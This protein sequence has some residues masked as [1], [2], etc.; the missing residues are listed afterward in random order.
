M[1]SNRL[2]TL[3]LATVSVTT[4]GCS[5]ND[6]SVDESADA[7]TGV[8]DLTE[9]EAAFG[10]VKDFKDAQGNWSRP[11]SKLENGPCFK[12]LRGG[13]DGASYEF[14]RYT[15]G[16]AFFKRENAGAASGPRRPVL[17]MDVDLA[18]PG[19][20]GESTLEFSDLE[21]D[22]AIR[23]RIGRPEGLEGA[24]GSTYSG[25]ENGYFRY[26]NMF[27]DGHFDALGK[28]ALESGCLS[29]VKFPGSNGTDASL[30]TLVYQY[31]WKNAQGTD[32]YSF[33]DD[34][35]GRYVSTD[36][37]A[38]VQHLRFEKL[39]AHRIAPSPSSPAGPTEMLAITRKGVDMGIVQAALAVC[40]RT[41]VGDGRYSVSCAGL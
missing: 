8:T 1:L 36:G 3:V 24:A 41:P 38:S 23:Y 7:V 14:R 37:D 16:A 4:F 17:C 39:D 19:L 29:E 9:V 22:A 32:L 30:V 35:V 13:P 12:K 31:A 33:Q 28:N 2:V 18:V 27:C 10:L 34:P 15:N 20:P 25:F 26:T 40:S 6:S 5:A 21:L 11:P